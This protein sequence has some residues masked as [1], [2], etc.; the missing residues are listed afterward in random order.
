MLVKKCH[1]LRCPNWL[2]TGSKASFLPKEEPA[3]S[4]FSLYSLV[5]I[6]VDLTSYNILN[7]P[8]D[9]ALSITVSRNFQESDDNRINSISRLYNSHN[10]YK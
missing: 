9:A 6:T 4:N 2:P 8:L 7:A 3:S 10:I 5:S 1:I